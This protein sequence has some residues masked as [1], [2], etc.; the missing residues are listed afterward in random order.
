MTTT[1]LAKAHE[2]LD[3]TV[4]KLYGFAKDMGE[5]EVVG[6]LMEKY[7]A[8]NNRATCKTGRFC[9]STDLG[10][11]YHKQTCYEFQPKTADGREQT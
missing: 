3:R 11:S 5:P 8:L 9:K 4:M 2:R 7:Q 6:E 10:A 1:G